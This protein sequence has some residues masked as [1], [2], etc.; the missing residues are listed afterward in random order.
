MKRATPRSR[1]MTVEGKG[2]RKEDR[3]GGRFR[4]G[5]RRDVVDVVVIDDKRQ[6][7]RQ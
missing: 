5:D 7:R 1:G 4:R 6:F 2:R 3:V